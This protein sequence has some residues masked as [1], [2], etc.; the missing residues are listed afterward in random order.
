VKIVVH[1]R[2]ICYISHCCLLCGKLSLRFLFIEK[3]DMKELI[4]L[5]T[6]PESD[7]QKDEALVTVFQSGKTTACLMN[8]N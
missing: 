6:T 8:E 3:R 2:D 5:I 1:L 4:E 7:P